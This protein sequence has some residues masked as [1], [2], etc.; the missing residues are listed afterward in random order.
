MQFSETGV[1]IDSLSSALTW[2]RSKIV[3][4]NFQG[5][6]LDQKSFTKCST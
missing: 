1:D 5:K 4:E 2:N 3:Y 6:A